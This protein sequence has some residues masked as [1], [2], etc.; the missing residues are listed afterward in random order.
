MRVLYG[1]LVS[2]TILTSAANAEI[3][4]RQSVEQEVVD[5]DAA[6]AV[7]IRRVDA[8]KVAPG[9]EVIYSLRYSNDSP[10]PAA[11]VTMVMPVPD[12]VTFT[13]G[14]AG[15]ADATI[16]FSADGGK[17]YLARGR[18]TITENG[19]Q[20]SATSDEITHIRWAISD[21]VAAG[22]TGEIFFRGVVK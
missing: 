9:E 7:K 15:G 13:E 5:R 2:T 3:V 22:G 12:A 20:R 16:T 18:L 21:P 17:T 10:E 4:A 11:G 6:G 14:S 19:A 8:D 1:F